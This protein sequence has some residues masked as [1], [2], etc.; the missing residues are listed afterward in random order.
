MG[1]SNPDL[2]LLRPEAA[3]SHDLLWVGA[4][5]I[6]SLHRH[7]SRETWGELGAA[8]GRAAGPAGA[9][10]AERGPSGP[11]QAKGDWPS[12]LFW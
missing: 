1:L 6:E 4:H 10:A 7:R 5:E 3:Q 11:P 8:D 12:V 9:G 2:R